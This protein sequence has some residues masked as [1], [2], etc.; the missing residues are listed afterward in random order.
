[1]KSGKKI[2]IIMT[3]WSSGCEGAPSVFTE[4]VVGQ[5]QTE[6]NR[7]RIDSKVIPQ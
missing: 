6:P 2:K 1:M 3:S 5:D 7:S 4:Q